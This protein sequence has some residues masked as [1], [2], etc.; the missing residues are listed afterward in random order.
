MQ[1]FINIRRSLQDNHRLLLRQQADHNK[2][3]VRIRTA[4]ANDEL[5]KVERRV[6][7][8]FYVLPPAMI[9]KSSLDK[10]VY[11]GGSLYG[12]PT[13]E[14]DSW[15]HGGFG[16]FCVNNG[17]LFSTVGT[18]VYELNLSTLAITD[19]E[20]VNAG[21][22]YV[23]VTWDTFPPSIGTEFYWHNV[24]NTMYIHNI[25]PMEDGK[26]LV[27]TG[28]T[29]RTE[30]YAPFP[31]QPH[32]Y[33]YRVVK[34]P[35]VA[36]I[37]SSDLSTTISSFTVTGLVPLAI[38]PVGEH[39]YLFHDLQQREKLGNGRTILKTSRYCT[40]VD[41]SG[42]VLDARYMRPQIFS[43]LSGGGIELYRNI[44]GR[45]STTGVRK[46]YFDTLEDGEYWIENPPTGLYKIHS[47]LTSAPQGSEGAYY[48]YANFYSYETFVGRYAPAISSK[49]QVVPSSILVARDG[50]FVTYDPVTQ[51]MSTISTDGT[52]ER[53][54]SLSWCDHIEDTIAGF[55][56]K[57]EHTQIAVDP[58]NTEYVY[59]LFQA[60]R[61]TQAYRLVGR[62]NIGADE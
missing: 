54:I 25:Y 60:Y 46:V 44:G 38:A 19:H 17:K 7:D 16:N 45:L 18:N 36:K 52:V 8:Q 55:R 5:A 49:S 42:D 3:D 59:M 10:T 6:F 4:W 23:K 43:M 56:V 30:R 51:M 47:G 35:G 40:I 2:W 61:G 9:K 57:H 29:H 31:A 48:L 24:K 11:P 50:G 20:S 1:S 15:Y 27:Y 21:Q 37:M 41:Q 22:E 14:Y 39:I 34:T 53:S 28:G 58:Y 33:H 32:N 26:F 62:L 13:G 12:I